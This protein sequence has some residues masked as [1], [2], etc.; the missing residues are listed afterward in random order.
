L[1]ELDNS[2]ALADALFILTSDHGE[3]FLEHNG[4]F[5][6]AT[7][8]EE[9]VK[10][11]IIVKA[12]RNDSISMRPVAHRD[13]VHTIMEAIGFARRP[14]PALT[15]RSEM[16]ERT[17]VQLLENV[18]SFAV[19]QGRYKS[20]VNYRNN[21]QMLFD[22]ESDPGETKDIAKIHPNVAQRFLKLTDFEARQIIKR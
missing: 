12:G 21:A 22:L 17:I 4:I 11:P 6:G 19:R 2:P 9:V 13:A 7:L 1:P 16:P 14:A 20:I 10:V 15:L 5:H 3:E 8:F 18:G